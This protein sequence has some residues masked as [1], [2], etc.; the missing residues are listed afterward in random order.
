M[1]LFI[2]IKLDSKCIKK[3]DNY[4]KFFYSENVS[5][6]YTSLENLHLTLY[7]LGEVDEDRINEI[8]SII[9]SVK[10]EI[11]ELEIIKFTRLKDMLVGEVK[12]TKELISIY[13]DLSNKL[14]QNGFKINENSFYPHITLI[15][16]VNNLKEFKFINSELNLK[17][18][19][20]KIT[21]F[22]STRINNKL[23][24]I[25]KN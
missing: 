3:I 25:P 24:Y 7:F 10:L 11:S 8:K 5:G 16:Q 22:E 9:N 23:V 17:F 1:R 21:L 20:N 12:K 2:G 13:N 18:S 6:N 14:K 15:R 19:F 4:Y